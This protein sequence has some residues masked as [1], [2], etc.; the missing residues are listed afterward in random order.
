MPTLSETPPLK[1]LKGFQ[2]IK[3]DKYN[4]IPLGVYVRYFKNGELKYGGFLKVMKHPD[5]MVLLN[6]KTRAT[7]S[8]QL[9]DPSLHVWI[10]DY[11]P[12]KTTE[13]NKHKKQP[14]I[15]RELEK[16]IVKLT[17]ANE[18]LKR[19]IE[20]MKEKHSKC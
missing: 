16:Q 20:K 8:V 9:K 18:K 15:S 11:N 4:T 19:K 5:Y 17:E 10:R 3:P 12:Q 7:W 1:L 6:L 2:E 13:M 14:H